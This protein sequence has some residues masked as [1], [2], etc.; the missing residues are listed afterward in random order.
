MKKAIL[1][2]AV[3]TLCSVSLRAQTPASPISTFSLTAQPI[4]LPGNHQTVAGTVAGMTFTPTTNFDLREDNVIVPGQNFQGY[5]GGFNYR[6]P[7]IST[8]VNNI[9]PNL[10][11][12]RFQF[13]L[14]GSAGVSIVSPPGGTSA[15][16]YA[17][18]AGG[19]IT[20]DITQSGSFA[21][22]V[23]VRYAKLPGLAN[24]TAIVSLGPSWHF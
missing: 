21:L 14:T 20:Y 3:L 19:G 18:L 22:G 6:L 16:H 17:F 15:S 4:A 10:N 13:Y 8:A 11:G 12:Y 9:S 2:L 1:F 5:F 24:N 7:V 23:E